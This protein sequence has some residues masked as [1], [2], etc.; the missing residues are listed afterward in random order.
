MFK[1]RLTWFAKS[2]II[3]VLLLLM[4]CIFFFAQGIVIITN[5]TKAVVE[6]KFI[7]KNGIYWFS[8]INV[9]KISDYP[10]EFDL[11]SELH[12]QTAEGYVYEC[13]FIIKTSTNIP[14][15]IEHKVSPIAHIPQYSLNSLILDKTLTMSREEL[16]KSSTKTMIEK[17]LEDYLQK[18]VAQDGIIIDKVRIYTPLTLVGKL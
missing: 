8:P 9:T 17:T 7:E 16:L 3:V 2:L 10:T 4:A 1:V 11:F 5:S 15:V 12:I 14:W 18:E 13:K 6:N